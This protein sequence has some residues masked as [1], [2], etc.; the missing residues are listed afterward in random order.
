M[1]MGITNQLL[2]DSHQPHRHDRA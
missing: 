2:Q 1:L